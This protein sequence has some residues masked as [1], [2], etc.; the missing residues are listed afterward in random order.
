MLNSLFFFRLWFL[1]CGNKKGV[2]DQFRKDRKVG[3]PTLNSSRNPLPQMYTIKI[4]NRSFGLR[5]L[6]SHFSEASKDRII[7]SWVNKYSTL[8]SDYRGRNEETRA[9]WPT[10]RDQWRAL[11][12][13]EGRSDKGNIRYTLKALFPF[14][15]LLSFTSSISGKE[16][17]AHRKFAFHVFGS[18]LSTPGWC[19]PSK[20]AKDKEKE[21]EH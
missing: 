9:P 13:L 1:S 19:F 10:V 6:E 8:Q 16:F 11:P 5:C 14:F 20:I 21:G 3:F 18:G 2:L 4:T 7:I 17:M 15:I 12:F